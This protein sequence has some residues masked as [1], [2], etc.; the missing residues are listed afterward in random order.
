MKSVKCWKTEACEITSYV[1]A[2]TRGKARAATLHTA[3]DAGFRLTFPEIRCRRCRIF[4]GMEQYGLETNRP[5]SLEIMTHYGNTIASR[6]RARVQNPS[7]QNH[8]N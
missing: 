1:F 8:G 2:R 4:D 3:R 6:A 5:Y 7:R